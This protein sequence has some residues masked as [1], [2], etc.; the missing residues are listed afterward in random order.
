[1]RNVKEISIKGNNKG[2]PKNDNQGITIIL[3]KEVMLTIILFIKQL[4][5]GVINID[6]VIAIIPKEIFSFR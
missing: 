1:M 6:I 5:N 2:I 4:S 3:L